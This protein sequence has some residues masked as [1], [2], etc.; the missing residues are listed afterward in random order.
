MFDTKSIFVAKFIIDT[1]KCETANYFDGHKLGAEHTLYGIIYTQ[2]WSCRMTH[3]QLN[4]TNF[5]DDFGLFRNIFPSF[6]IGNFQ[7]YY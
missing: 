7:N 6:K 4:F 2:R 5:I 3:V 1:M